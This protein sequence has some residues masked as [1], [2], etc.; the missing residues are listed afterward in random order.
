MGRCIRKNSIMDTIETGFGFEEVLIKECSKP[1]YKTHLVKESYLS[2]FSEP[3]EKALVR[4]NLEVYSKE[5]VDKLVIGKISTESFIT[6]QQVT[7]MMANLD[8]VNS[9]LK[10]YADYTIP[11]NLF[12][13]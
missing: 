4:A 3:T 11:S 6:K 9:T 2:E 7:E 10:A 5:E 12:K 1:K 8:F 13:L